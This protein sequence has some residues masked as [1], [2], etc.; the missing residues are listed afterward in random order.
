M[1][2]P[3]EQRPFDTVMALIRLTTILLGVYWLAIFVATHLPS[4]SLPSLGSDKTYHLIA[5]GGLS[6]LLSW[7]MS[8]TIRSVAKQTVMVLAICMLYALFDEWSQQFVAGRQPDVSDVLADAYGTVLGV[9][10]FRLARVWLPREAPLPKQ[11]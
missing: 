11:A 8:Q 5:F 10:A 1:H 3:V 2:T 7:V 9:L 4:S 6:L